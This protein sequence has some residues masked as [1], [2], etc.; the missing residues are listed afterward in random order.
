MARPLTRLA[1][2]P[3][4]PELLASII[5]HYGQSVTLGHLHIY[6]C[7]PR[8]LTLFFEYGALLKQR[9]GKETAS[10]SGARTRGA[11]RSSMGGGPVG[12]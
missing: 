10:V 6:Q 2:R 7:L 5:K 3:F 4:P 12:V 1:G 11:G 8:L 9:Q